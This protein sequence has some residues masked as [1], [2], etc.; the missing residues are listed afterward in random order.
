MGGLVDDGSTDSTTRRER[1]R[2]RRPDPIAPLHG[3]PITAK[4]WI[5]VAG[6]PCAGGSTH[7][8]DR[9][10]A[11]DATVVARLRAAGA[12]VLAKTAAGDRSE[13]YGITRNPFD[14][15]RSPGAS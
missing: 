3:V 1:E 2:D 12:I 9:R 11:N 10:P 4:D 13:V 14:P 15:E 7:H 6:F 8:R 5:D